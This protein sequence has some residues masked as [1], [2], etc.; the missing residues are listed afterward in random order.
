MLVAT[1][2]LFALCWGPVL[3]E[4]VL[5]AYGYLPRSKSGTHKHLHTVFQLMSYL[6]RYHLLIT[7]KRVMVT[8]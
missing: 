8:L 2:L 6:N 4:N 5:T 1:V 7:V 3:V